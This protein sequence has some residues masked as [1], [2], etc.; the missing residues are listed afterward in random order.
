MGTPRIDFLQGLNLNPF[1]NGG[2]R[3]NQRGNFTAA[4]GDGQ[5]LADRFR[6]TNSTT[7]ELTSS[8]GTGPQLSDGIS[9]PLP[10]SRRLDVTTADTTIASGLRM[11]FLHRLELSQ[12]TWMFYSRFKVGFWVKTN[13]TGTYTADLRFGINGANEHDYLYPFEVA[14]ADV[15]TKVEF[16]V[17]GNVGR[18]LVGSP[19]G[20]TNRGIEILITL[21]ADP[22][23][24]GAVS[25]ETFVPISVIN[26]TN[27]KGASGQVNFLDSTSNYIE[28]SGFTCQPIQTENQDI[29]LWAAPDVPFDLEF[30]R[31]QR[32]YQEVGRGIQGF[33]VSST[34]V[35]LNFR[36][37]EMRAD[38][39]IGLESPLRVD[40]DAASSVTAASPVIQNSLLSKNGVGQLLIG[41]FSGSTAFDFAEVFTENAIKLDA[42]L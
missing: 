10:A 20:S 11:A 2:M 29:D 9:I 6:L 14:D 5:Y 38:P 27:I 35:R 19:D 21:A 33:W 24:I 12:T 41:G 17:D 34:Q 37:N 23:L 42:E 30:F 16:E 36:I 32:Y 1:I 8:S 40:R 7:G 13:K 28:F 22:A 4:S 15:W 25:E 18:S 26:G 39:T 31:C 3:F